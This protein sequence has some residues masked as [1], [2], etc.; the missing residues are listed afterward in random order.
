MTSSASI[1]KPTPQTDIV[2]PKKMHLPIVTCGVSS[3]KKWIFSPVLVCVP[4]ETDDQTPG[5]K[6]MGQV[7]HS[8]SM[9]F[10]NAPIE[11][12]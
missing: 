5:N 8:V 4:G 6:N 10:L 9:K 1:L 12:A 2:H 3:V 11:Q 7:C